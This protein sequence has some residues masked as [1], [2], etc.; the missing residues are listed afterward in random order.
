MLNELLC[1]FDIRNVEFLLLDYDS[2]LQFYT[3]FPPMSRY[4]DSA[5]ITQHSHYN[6]ILVLQLSP[7][8]RFPLHKGD[9]V[10]L[11]SDSVHLGLAQVKFHHAHIAVTRSL[12]SP[13]ETMVHSIQVKVWP[14][15][16]W[17]W[18]LFFNGMMTTMLTMMGSWRNLLQT[19]LATI[20]SR[21]IRGFNGHCNRYWRGSWCTT[22]LRYVQP[23][24]SQQ[25]KWLAK[26][27]RRMS[28]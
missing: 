19:A 23:D 10:G 9:P 27:A 18:C 17:R 26:V 24:Y 25:D 5:A 16:L 6:A 28:K 20:G 15:C 8:P 12:E 1:F 11:R 3:L 21:V 13:F 4:Y 7:N 2:I 22:I 14:G